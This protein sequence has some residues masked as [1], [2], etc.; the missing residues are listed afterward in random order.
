MRAALVLALITL[1]FGQPDW[2][3]HRLLP[4]SVVV[5]YGTI[6]TADG[7][8]MTIE[9]PIPYA[10]HSFGDDD[11]VKAGL[12][13]FDMADFPEQAGPADTTGFFLAF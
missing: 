2:P 5:D 10:D 6:S 1:A 4:G 9:F 12:Y 3:T 7:D 13:C 11:T 8:S